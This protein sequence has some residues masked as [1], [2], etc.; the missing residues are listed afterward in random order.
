MALKWNV[1]NPMTKTNLRVE[2]VLLTPE[3]AAQWLECNF[4]NRPLNNG[5]IRSYESAISRGE[6]QVNGETIVFCDDGSL[7]SGQHRCHAVISAGKPIETLVVHGVSR[8][9]FPTMDL[10]RRRNAS[11]SLGIDGEANTNRLAAAVRT[12]LTYSMTTYEANVISPTQIRACLAEHPEIRYWVQKT[13]SSKQVRKFSSSLDGYM[14][15]A[16]EKHGIAKLD[17]FFEQLDSGIGLQAGSPA[18]LLRERL[19]N[20]T[21]TRVSKLNADAFMIKAI[22]AHIAGKTL[23]FLRLNP[24]EPFPRLV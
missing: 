18:L 12:Y 3:L 16:S 14:A 6:W 8:S 11:D 21:V 19:L 1:T 9:A 22:N 7:A 24:S 23:S 2:L 15:L 4:G 17:E 5:A 20:Q 10:G 13:I